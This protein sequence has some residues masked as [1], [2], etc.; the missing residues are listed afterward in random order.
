MKYFT[1][2]AC[3]AVCCLAAAG[4]A[5]SGGHASKEIEA[6]V[7][8]RKA[9]MTLYSFNLGL[10][11][12][13]AKGEIEYDAAAAK[14]AAMNIAAL[15]ATDQLRMWLPGSDT[16]SF[17]EGTRALPK[18]WTAES[19]ASDIGK[20]MGMAAAELSNVAGD[21][22]DALRQKGVTRVLAVPAMLFAAGHA[23]NDIPSVLTTYTAET[24]LP[25][26]YGR[27]LGVDRLIMLALEAEHLD[28]VLA[29][30][31]QRA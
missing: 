30:P 24:G 23:K 27:E 10:L 8:A 4:I 25:I 20:A 19:K 6:A 1:T 28:Q 5:T 11:G 7:K 3:S 31:V 14:A 29:F 9:Q 2:L 17:G 16:E 22:L 26:D 13:M 21:G 12:G 18:I 15:T